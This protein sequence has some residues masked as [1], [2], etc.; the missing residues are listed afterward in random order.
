MY[1]Q[2]IMCWI[3]NKKSSVFDLSPKLITK[4]LHYYFLFQ[5]TRCHTRRDLLSK[6]IQNC[7][8]NANQ[9]IAH[10]STMGRDQNYE[11]WD[12][13]QNRRTLHGTNRE[14]EG[15]GFYLCRRRGDG[16]TE[17]GSDG[18]SI[19]HASDAPERLLSNP[20]GVSPHRHFLGQS[21][22]AWPRSEEKIENWKLGRQF[23][24]KSFNGR[25]I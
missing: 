7:G 3:K 21:N 6:N 11:K 16:E 17:I 2:W 5:R 20:G 9:I 4:L 10:R 22:A 15:G 25:I 23:T 8:Y 24:F 18:E 1:G 19:G 14:S 12:K 13:M